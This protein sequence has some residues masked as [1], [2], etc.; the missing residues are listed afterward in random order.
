VQTYWALEPEREVR[1]ASDAA[2]AER[3]RELFTEAV[4]CRLRSAYPIGS[5]FSGGLDSSCVT[6]VTRTLLAEQ[7]Q[8]PLHTLSAFFTGAGDTDERPFINAV[9]AQGNL[10]SHQRDGNHL[11]AT[12]IELAQILWHVEEPFWY[13]FLLVLWGLYRVARAQRVRVLLDGTDGDSTVADCHQAYLAE[14]LR[15]GQWRT[16]AAEIHGAAQYGA[17]SQMPTW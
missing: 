15:T 5:V 1:L 2:Y 9:L 17:P 11:G 12:A 7:D 3:F 4:R 14:L 10:V 16:F 8:G 6:C 13:S